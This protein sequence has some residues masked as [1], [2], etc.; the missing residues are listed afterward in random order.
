M[1]KTIAQ[2]EAFL[3]SPSRAEEARLSAELANQSIRHLSLDS[4]KIQSSDLFIAIQGEQRHGLDFLAQVLEK[5]PAVIISDR[6]LQEAETALLQQIAESAPPVYVVENIASR[7]GL[8]ADWFYDQPSKQ[9]NV[10]GITG[11]NGKTSTAFYTAQLL[12]AQQQ[13]VAII[14]T[15]GNGSLD[16]LQPTANTT[17]DAVQV[18]RLLFEFLQAGYQW[19]VMEVSSHALCLG[20]IQAVEFNTVALT[21]VTRDHIDFHGS[22]AAYQQAKQVLFTD[23]S[24]RYKVLNMNDQNGRTVYRTL[25]AEN[26]IEGIWRYNA[27]EHPAGSEV[28]HAA[29]LQALEIKLTPQGITCR[30]QLGEEIQQL[31]TQLMGSFNIE[32]LFAA[33]SILLVNE[34]D[35]DKMIEQVSVLQPVAGR[36][37]LIHRQPTV[38][39]DFAH[40]PDALQQVLQATQAHLGDSQGKLIT[41][42]G[43]GGNRDQ[44]K[45]PL[46][47]SVAESFSDEV[48][49]TSD[50]PRDEEPLHIIKQIMKG[51]KEP[52]FIQLEVNR[53]QAIEKVLANASAEDIV[54]IAGKGHEDYQEIRGV[55]H[56]YSDQ[57]VVDSWYSRA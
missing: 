24:S 26:R 40:T 10:I 31:E 19:V 47:G 22:E 15:L 35:A 27:A 9:L 21:Q 57:S 51:I 43:C 5:Q 48:V 41:V 45:R 39:I 11:T 36:M 20:R 28:E 23:Y 12:Q 33:I 46:M 25:Q 55:K 54:L 8:L 56:P 38:I 34:F 4:R 1:A 17:P 52:E 6:A 32:N 13:K 2:L 16:D 42:F 44:G 7:Q 30:F 14:G 3:Y 29:E 37:Q 53:V 18:H 50:N 49:L